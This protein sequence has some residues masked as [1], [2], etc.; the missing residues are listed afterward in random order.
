[1]KL[2]SIFNLVDSCYKLYKNN[3]PKF[4][5]L[6][7]L[8]L[9]DISC[10]KVFIYSLKDWLMDDKDSEI[11][12]NRTY[13]EKEENLILLETMD[14]SHFIEIKKDNLTKII[15][16]WEKICKEKPKKVIINQDDDGY[17]TLITSN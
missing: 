14:Y 10:S 15:D 13:L 17:I 8:L 11:T 9:D 5:A 1:M 12:F 16:H 2:Q 4:I 7:R 3:D 6:I